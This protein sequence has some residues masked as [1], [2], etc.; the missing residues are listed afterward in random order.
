MC[1]TKKKSGKLNQPTIKGVSSRGLFVVDDDVE[2]FPL[3]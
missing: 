3:H 1:E 2:D